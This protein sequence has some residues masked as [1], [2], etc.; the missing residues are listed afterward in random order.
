MAVHYTDDLYRA[1]R[2]AHSVQANVMLHFIYAVWLTV[3]III[4]TILFYGWIA[5]FAF[6]A[7]RALRSERRP[8][9]ALAFA[10]VALAPLAWFASAY[11]SAVVDNEQHIAMVRDATRLPRLSDAPRVL[12]VHAGR[13]RWQDE[14]VDMGAFE[15]IYVTWPVETVR[16]E[17]ARRPGCDDA[18]RRGVIRARAGF[19]VCATETRVDRFP[20]DG[21]HFFLGTPP[22]SGRQEW[23]SRYELKLIE[24]GRERLIGF[25]G[26]PMV[27]HPIVPPVVM[28]G[29]LAFDRF[30]E[31]ESSLQQI[32]PWH[33]EI[34]FLFDRLNLDVDKL[35]PSRQ[36]SAEDVHAEFLRRFNS[37]EK[38]DHAIASL[39]ATAV[40]NSVLS[41][42]DIAPLLASGE[43]AGELARQVGYVQICNQIGRLCDF[44]GELVAACKGTGASAR[45]GIASH[46]ERIPRQCQWC[47]TTP[48][49]RPYLGKVEACSKEA[50]E[51]RE[52]SLRAIRELR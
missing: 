30:M 48:L 24:G 46:C 19:L 35:R 43:L 7:W 45:T 13:S 10:A 8:R 9:S 44:A 52:A 18:T 33:G 15:T 11:R 42:D 23:Q 39:I 36:P 5:Y 47:D 1:I 25:H 4:P 17:N 40:G 49:C 20:A 37:P 21:M 51:A 29:A 32:V 12:V 16:I 28:L 22:T 50:D 2:M 31:S 14:L 3:G 41:A 38:S 34:P 26:T 27:H 6:R